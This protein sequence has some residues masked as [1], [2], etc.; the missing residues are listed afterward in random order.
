MPQNR[1]YEL[2]TVKKSPIL[3]LSLLTVTVYCRLRCFVEYACG[4]N[5]AS[6]RRPKKS[7]SKTC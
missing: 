2:R 6:K 5:Y 3:F 4:G 7:R 1:R